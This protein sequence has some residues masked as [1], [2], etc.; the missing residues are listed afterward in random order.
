MS[1]AK[2]PRPPSPPLALSIP[3]GQ[4]P[5]PTPPPPAS[6][7]HG[8]LIGT[9]RLVSPPTPAPSPSPKTREPRNNDSD[10]S[11]DAASGW[12]VKQKTST[13][14]DDPKTLARAAQV[15]RYWNA[16]LQDEK[17]WRD[18]FAHTQ[19]L[20]E[21]APNPLPAS[22]SAAQSSTGSSRSAD[23]AGPGRGEDTNGKGKERDRRRHAPQSSM[24][25]ITPF[26]LEKRVIN[27]ASG[28]LPPSSST[29]TKHS[30]SRS[31]SVSPTPAP[32][33]SSSYKDQV[34]VAYLTENN[35]L[36]GG[37]LLAKH[38]SADDSVVTTLC[39]NEKYI[40]VG[41]ANN[42]IHV[43]SAASG[44][45]KRSLIGHQQGVWA[46]VLVTPPS[47]S[48]TSKLSSSS[49][50]WSHAN[51]NATGN[52]SLGWAYGGLPSESYRDPG[53]SRRAS[54]GALYDI[55]TPPLSVGSNPESMYPLE[56]RGHES[57]IHTVD[58]SSFE[59][60]PRPATAMGYS[61]AYPH[62]QESLTP[63][64]D[65][66]NWS[67][68]EEGT[69]A[70]LGGLGDEDICG[71]TYGWEGME[72][73]LV[74]SG[75]CD[76][77]VKVWNA[78]TGQLVHSLSAHTSTIRCIKVFPHSSLA[79]S[80]SRDFSLRIWDIRKGELKHTLQGHTGS[81]RCVEVWG[82]KAV[83]GS[84]DHTARM[85]DSKSGECLHTFSGHYA[86]IYSIACN[87]QIVI[88]GSLDSTVRVWSAQTGECL[89]LLQGHT[90][91]VGQ[92]QLSGNRLYTGGSDGRVIIFDLASLSCIH[93]LCAHDNSVTCLQAS[94]RFIVSGGNDGRVKLW[95]ARTGRFVR[96]LT[97]PCDAVWRV[98]FRGDR[99]V[100][101]CQ[102]EG[103]T[104]LEIISFRAGEGERRVK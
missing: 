50:P 69:G 60:F 94:P 51:L 62:P 28:V 65:Q 61:Q 9:S 1:W 45:Y 53:N 66:P 84:Y 86:E 52:V 79:I 68:N 71:S 49:S 101:L 39:F 104:C 82:D 76:R 100:V 19:S 25:R 4:V 41:M 59:E 22:K 56:G 58:P 21:P 44:G 38:L 81:V 54:F 46:M 24:K 30:S 18:L 14:V 88:T 33:P 83:S 78:E 103:R 77:E 92:L 8:H 98:G 34:K 70:G 102:R 55:K 7:N 40:I 97:K 23:A 15:S 35:W 96:E 89:A 36:I 73:H 26:G 37:V 16:L 3:R 75:G 91:L 93:R 29:L 6:Q 10:D 13:E 32:N 85:W 2:S 67:W 12:Q 20:S 74:V 99:I 57:G 72:N 63:H 11:D 47:A 87:G 64:A 43:F 48:S 42:R 80:G 27:V 17:L 31:S 95:D 90:A 5:L